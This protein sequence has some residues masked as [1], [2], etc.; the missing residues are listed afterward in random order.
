MLDVGCAHGYVAEVLVRQGC[1]VVGVERDPEDAARARRHCEE[2]VVADLDT[3]GWADALGA[4]RFDVIVFADVLEHVRDPAA[5]VRRACD[6]LAPGGMLVASIPNVAHVSVRLELLLG[7]FRRETLGILDATHLHFFTRETRSRPCSPARASPSS[8]GTA[9]RTTS[10][11]RSWPTT[12]RARRFRHTGAAGRLR[13]VRGARLP[14]R[15]PRA[16]DGRRPPRPTAP[17]VEKPLGRSERL[18]TGDVDTPRDGRAPRAPG[19][20][21]VP[22]ATHRAARRSTPPTSR[23][24]SPGAG[25]R[26]ASSPARPGGRT[27]RTSHL[28]EG[29]ATIVVDRIPAG[30]E[31]R[32]LGP[33]AFFFD[34]FDNPEARAAARGILDTMRPD[35]VHV[36]QLLYLSARGDSRRRGGGA[37]RSS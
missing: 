14:V 11:R 34:R 29:D 19:R 4:R 5:V 12:W 13:G 9:R 24:R 23:S 1:R 16:P 8:T 6:L 28:L 26:C 25:T 35:V 37:S 2:V 30:R 3:P 27:R 7:S 21:P 20:A 22:A 32:A 17:A 10:T 15:H 18:R 36:Q 31:Y 33:V